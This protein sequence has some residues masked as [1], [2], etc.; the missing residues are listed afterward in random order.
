MIGELVGGY[1]V[2]SQLGEG[3]M[4]VVFLAEHTT[5][6]RKAAV[7][8][9]HPRLSSDKEMVQ[10]FFNEA[11]AAGSISHP[12]IVSVF[13]LGLRDD[14]S[15]YI[16]MDFLQGESLT[17][18][19]HSRGAGECDQRTDLYAIGIMLFEL[20]TGRPPFTGSV[21]GDLMAAHMRDVPPTLSETLD[22]TLVELETIVATLL[23]KSPNDR[24]ASGEIAIAKIDSATHGVLSSG[25]R[26]PTPL[27]TNRGKTGAEDSNSD[28]M[29][30][31]AIGTLPLHNAGARRFKMPLAAQQSAKYLNAATPVGAWQ[32]LALSWLLSELRQFW[33]C[34]I[35]RPPPHPR[36]LPLRRKPSLRLSPQTQLSNSRM[37]K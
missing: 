13:D 7:K 33:R 28:P 3:G 24:Y 6:G 4:G 19:L 20:L 35:R 22:P 2:I 32:P 9:L 12:G 11:Q 23:A 21:L 29:A 16:V 1:R 34:G 27:P 25:V 26:T 8:I 18:R 30:E 10:R 15:A 36:L 5:M 17:Q 14:G 37:S 31:T